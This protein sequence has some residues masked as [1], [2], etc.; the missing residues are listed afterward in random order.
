MPYEY[1]PVIP[2]VC[3]RVETT[4]S[5]VNGV[6]SRRL[7]RS[8]LR[9]Q[10]TVA[11]IVMICAL[12]SAFVP[13]LVSGASAGVPAVED[14]RLDPMIRT[15]LAAQAAG[16]AKEAVPDPNAVVP[17]LVRGD[18]SRESL[19][20]LGISVGVEA[21][22]ITTADVPLQRFP[23]LMALAGIA[24]VEAAR[25]L[26]PLLNI[27]A[28][29]IDAV[30][31]WG[32]STSPYTPPYSGVTGSGV[33]V[34]VIDTG[35]DLDHQ[36]FLDASGNTRVKYLWDQTGSSNPPS[37][38]TYGR[39][40]TASQ[41]NSNLAT[42]VDSDGHGTHIAG[43]A[44]GNGRATGQGYPAFRYVGIAPNADLVIVKST[45]QFESRVID[46][47]SYV[48]QKAA[49]LNKSAVV[50]IA[51]GTH[52]GAHDGSY[53]LDEAISALTGPR[54]LVVAAAGNDA[55]EPVHASRIVSSAGQ[56]ASILFSIPP[57]APS[58]SVLEYVELEGWHDPTASFD[59]KLTSPTGINTG[60]IL[61]GASANLPSSTSGGIYLENAVTS[62]SSGAKKT[63]VYLS[64]TGYGYAPQAG[65][66]KIEVRRRSGTQSG[67]FDSWI[68]GEV[69]PG[70][71]L[72]VAYTLGIDATML[73]R[74]PATGDN[75]IAVG[76]YTTKTT[77][78]NGAGGTSFYPGAP[79]LGQIADF[80][81]VGPR[82]DGVQRPDV[83]APGY[84]VM[85][86]LSTE[87]NGGTST[88]WQAEDRVHRIQKG[89]SMAAAHVAGGLALFLQET[90]TM[91][92]AM[93]R[94][95]LTSTAISD[96]WTG[97]VPNSRWGAGKLRLRGQE[98]TSVSAASSTSGATHWLSPNPS[99]A[100]VT[101]HF[102]LSADDV[103]RAGDSVPLRIFD[104]AGRE[105]HVL[106]ARNVAGVQDLV[107]DGRADEGQLVAPGV[108]FGRLGSGEAPI[109]W[110]IL[111][112][113]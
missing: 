17:T 41:I 31:Y 58:G 110:K 30:E 23:E 4:V 34:G 51:F 59:V 9:S 68:V 56:T 97:S 79:A 44:A 14:T 11:A 50:L 5:P 72:P 25:P 65:V 108:Y 42:E 26:Q 20:A 52:R 35:L 98:A 80:S 105:V 21:G 82:R 12:S 101:F 77:W 10:A 16:M 43:I 74:S 37:G 46:G 63:R 28:P 96:V 48:F 89:T 93:A 3:P 13:R 24:E 81:S 86:A 76:A 39:E 66:W 113:R 85:A 75:V 7:H 33:I 61:P 57:Y 67:R 94:A 2:G 87:V 8:A 109:V 102:N 71:D 64:D 38:F 55:L 70:A 6:I 100:N 83:T 15:M 1:S 47:V 19:E 99:S 92:P 111:R 106:S 27:S 78:T 53:S 18:V 32:E 107:W 112:A 90:P 40:W 84:G 91:T 49:Q 73:V 36:D 29:E 60:W 95:R 88:T 22:P 45:F 62:S 69:L 104:A 54:K 103:L